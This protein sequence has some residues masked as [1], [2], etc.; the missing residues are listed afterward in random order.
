MLMDCIKV[1]AEEKE[2]WCRLYYLRPPINVK[3]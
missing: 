1:Q 2:D 3:F